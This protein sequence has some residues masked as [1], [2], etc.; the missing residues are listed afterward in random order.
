MAKRNWQN[1]FL[2]GNTFD[3]KVQDRFASLE[4]DVAALGGSPVTSV[5]AGDASITIGGTATAPTV[6]VST[7]GQVYTTNVQTSSYTLVLADQGK[8]VEMN[9]ASAN[10]VT[11]PLNASVAFPVGTVISIFQLGAGQTQVLA[12]GGV[13]LDSPSAKSHLTGQYSSAAI[14]KRG[15]DEWVLAGDLA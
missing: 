13:T 12:A 10:T 9:N 3:P 4:N 7:A 6:A 15:T 11:I 8:I 14:R 1:A 2:D 5:S